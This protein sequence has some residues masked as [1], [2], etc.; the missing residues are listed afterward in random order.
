[1]SSAAGLSHA[2]LGRRWTV[3]WT[4]GG[5]FGRRAEKKGC[6]LGLKLMTKSVVYGVFSYLASCVTPIVEGPPSSTPRSFVPIA[7]RHAQ[8]ARVALIFSLK[9]TFW[10]RLHSLG[11][12]FPQRREY[13]PRHPQ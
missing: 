8:R 13:F 10:P 12:L 3:A 11:N 1:M 5:R 9:N 7:G 4:V 6:A 2:A